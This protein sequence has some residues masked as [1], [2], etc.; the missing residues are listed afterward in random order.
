MCYPKPGP[1][2]SGSAAMRLAA[3]KQAVKNSEAHEHENYLKL[4]EVLKKA[5]E[6]FDS[7]P[8]G[9]AILKDSQAHGDRS[10]LTSMRYELAKQ[11]RE[12]QLA[13]MKELGLQ[14]KPHEHGTDTQ[15]VSVNPAEFLADDVVRNNKAQVVDV[16]KLHELSDSWVQGL[17]A[18]ELRQ[19]YWMTDRG[20]MEANTFIAG[21]TQH[22]MTSDEDI[23][24][25]MVVVDSA[26]SK[27][28]AAEPVIVYRGARQGSLPKHMHDNYRISKEEKAAEFLKGFTEGDVFESEFFMP[29]S[30]NPQIANRFS[31]FNVTYEIK[32]KKA[33]PLATF[34]ILPHEQEALLPRNSKFR[35][36]AIKT[37][38]T[39]AGSRPGENF[40]VIQLEEL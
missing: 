20:A 22:R 15:H 31:D 19:L 12:L 38:I 32:T 36:A 23:Q 14:N 34:S 29:T 3:A 33:A 1:R 37:G 30:Y 10:D 4:R 6:E 13:E 21:H 9:L 8:A 26:L 40:T 18:E 2:C 5:Q 25:R 39:Y 28:E 27:Y 16:D 7:T 35:V 11:R 24:Q 17:D